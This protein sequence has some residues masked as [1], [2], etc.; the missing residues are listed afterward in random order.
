[1]KASTGIFIA[2]GLGA[3]LLYA[4]S[5][6]APE[7]PMPPLPGEPDEDDLPVIPEDATDVE[8]VNVPEASEHFSLDNITSVVQGPRLAGGL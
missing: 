1:M 4:N 8:Y 5:N 6:N 2:L 7:D 3:L